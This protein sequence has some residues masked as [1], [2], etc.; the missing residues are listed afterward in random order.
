MI[1]YD[2]DGIALI[3]IIFVISKSFNWCVN[4]KRIIVN[5]TKCLRASKITQ[6]LQWYSFSITISCIEKINWKVVNNI[7][8]LWLKCKI[9]VVKLQTINWYNVLVRHWQ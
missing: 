1:K 9:K 8:M 4:T 7:F 3:H 6:Y 2:D 5:P